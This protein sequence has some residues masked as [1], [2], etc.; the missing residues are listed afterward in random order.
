MLTSGSELTLTVSASTIAAPGTMV[1][2]IGLV[3]EHARMQTVQF[4]LT[5]T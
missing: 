2:T 4:V 1:L 3:D 5:V